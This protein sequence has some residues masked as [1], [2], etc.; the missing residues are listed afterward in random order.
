MVNKRYLVI[1]AIAALSVG[2]YLGFRHISNRYTEATKSAQEEPLKVSLEEPNLYREAPKIRK[3]EPKSRWVLS[4]LGDNG[5]DNIPLDPERFHDYVG[6]TPGDDGRL[7]F[8]PSD[9]ERKRSGLIEIE[10]PKKPFS[11]D[12]PSFMLIEERRADGKMDHAFIFF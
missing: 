7:I 3:E 6:S 8:T 9:E 10:I 4:H 2:G 5:F 1:P 11:M 12:T